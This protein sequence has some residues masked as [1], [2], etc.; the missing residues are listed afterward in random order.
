MAVNDHAEDHWPRGCQDAQSRTI[1]RL[2]C[3]RNLELSA[4]L[5]LLLVVVLTGVILVMLN[6]NEMRPSKPAVWNCYWTAAFIAGFTLRRNTAWQSTSTALN[7]RC[8][9]SGT[10]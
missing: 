4:S 6:P 7:Q 5:G 1:A 9:S 8:L 3:L 10:F 2:K